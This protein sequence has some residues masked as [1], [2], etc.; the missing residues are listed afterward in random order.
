M[1]LWSGPDRER[2][3]FVGEFAH[4]EVKTTTGKEHRHEISMVNQLTAPPNKSLLFASLILEKSKGGAESIA[5]KIDQIREKLGNDGRAIDAFERSLSD[6]NWHEELRQTGE[7]LRF[8]LMT[9][10]LF[11]VDDTFPRLPSDFVMPKG[12]VSMKY[13]IDVTARPSLSQAEVAKILGCNKGA[14]PPCL[15]HN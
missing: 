8:N 7:L 4:I 13:T 3:D 6:M 12:I 15:S 14:R 1:L 10:L 11:L 5:E 9:P 2:H